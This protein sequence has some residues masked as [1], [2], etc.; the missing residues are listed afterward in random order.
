VLWP[1]A[2]RVSDLGASTAGASRYLASTEGGTSPCQFEIL[3]GPPSHDGIY[4][5]AETAF[6]RRPQSDCTA[7][8]RTVAKQIGFEGDLPRTEPTDR[9][10]ASIAILGSNQ[11]RSGTEGSF[12][13]SPR[14]HWISAKLFLKDG[15]GEV[16]LNLSAPDGAGEFS[17]KDA[18][19]ASIVVTELAKILLPKAD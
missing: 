15:E 3:I 13:S 14:G 18:E 1:G 11:S 17:I 4:A 7:L 19:Y 9:L 10:P 12:S 16:Y 2:F 6:I 8:L 5:I